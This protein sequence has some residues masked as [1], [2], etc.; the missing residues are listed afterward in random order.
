MKLKAFIAD[1]W[2]SAKK[3][4]YKKDS[5]KMRNSQDPFVSIRASFEKTEW[6]KQLIFSF[7]KSLVFSLSTLCHVRSFTNCNYSIT[8]L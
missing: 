4:N 1:R 8:S 6:L 7:M 2:K 5:T 3:K